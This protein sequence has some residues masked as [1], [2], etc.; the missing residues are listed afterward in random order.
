MFVM[1]TLNE[2]YLRLCSSTEYHMKSLK[3][4]NRKKKKISCSYLKEYIRKALNMK[5]KL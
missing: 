5:F 3:D 2:K 1:H 4:Q